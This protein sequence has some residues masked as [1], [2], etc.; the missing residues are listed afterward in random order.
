VL[1]AKQRKSGW[2]SIADTLSTTTL[3]WRKYYEPP[4][5]PHDLSY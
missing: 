3:N 4:D 5:Q 2:L 1:S